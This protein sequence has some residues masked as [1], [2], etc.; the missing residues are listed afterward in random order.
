MTD[1]SILTQ[2]VATVA[3]D[4]GRAAMQ[5]IADRRVSVTNGLF[6]VQLDAEL[7][8]ERAIVPRLR[9]LI[10][11]SEV[12][13]EE[14]VGLV[15]WDKSDVWIVD[16]LGGVNNYYAEIPY[17]AISIGLRRWRKL[18]MAV[19]YD[20]VLGH[21]YRACL[22]FGA[23]RN[24]VRLGPV[25][26]KTID[27]ATVSL[28]TD[29]SSDG[30]SAGEVLYLKLNSV[31]RRVTTLWTPAAD[32]VRVATGHMDAIV[33]VRAGYANV[34]GG[35]LILSEAGGTIFDP[36]GSDLDVAALDPETPVSFI[37]AASRS[38]AEELSKEI[39]GEFEKYA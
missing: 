1:L 22:G 15:D 19:V 30:R 4:A 10:P 16:Q 14:M 5:R 8:A 23:E 12:S 26:G 18:E 38:M 3:A 7:D 37:A 9:A 25:P 39:F 33:C 17:L 6:G 20:P 34:C 32:L 2:D 36:S 21:S 31:T 29:H 24:G 35:L 27:R 11:G 28:I 13:S